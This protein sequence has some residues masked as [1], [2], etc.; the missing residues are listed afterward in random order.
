[1]PSSRRARATTRRIRMRRLRVAGLLVAIAA[2][3]ALGSQ[4]LTSSP[5]SATSPPDVPRRALHPAL[6]KVPSAV[7]P[8]SGQAAFTQT[9]R[10]QVHAGPNQHAASIASVAKVMTA[11]L[12]LRDHPLAPGQE[13]P[14]ITVTD[15]DVLDTERRR[16]QQESIVSI[17]AG[18]QLTER[19]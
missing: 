15:A 14:T 4:L 5:S 19:Q 7:W 12:V 3:A 6:D 11:Y 17:A 2:S 16:R 9:G 1:M 10:S 13:G 8:A 18:E